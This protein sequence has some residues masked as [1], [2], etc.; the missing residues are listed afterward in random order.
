MRAADRLD[1][2]RHY[3]RRLVT[4]AIRTATVADLPAL[5]EM[6]RTFTFEDPEPSAT[7]RDDY[8]QAFEEIVGAGIASGRWTVWVAEADG[9]IV[10]HVYVGLIEKIPRP[11]R[12]DRWIGYVTNVYTRPEQRGRGVGAA[13]LERVTH[14]AAQ[15]DVEL[16]VVWPSEEGVGVY[17]RAGFASGRDPLVWMRE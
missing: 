2:R 13:L 7:L 15:E 8:E 4:V 3:A 16:L 14:W 9:A 12:E 5:A 10:S 17:Q 1:A 11:T 6:R